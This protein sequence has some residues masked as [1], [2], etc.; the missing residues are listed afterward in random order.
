MMVNVEATW[1]KLNAIDRLD[2]KTE[3]ISEISNSESEEGQ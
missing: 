2:D 3:E 1:Q